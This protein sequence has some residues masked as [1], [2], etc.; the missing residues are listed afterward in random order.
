[1]PVS[2]GPSVRQASFAAFAVAALSTHLASAGIFGE[3][4]GVWDKLWE[5]DEKK[6]EKATSD[7]SVGKLGNVVPTAAAPDTV[8]AALARA[9][10]QTSAVPAVA[11][12]VASPELK[13]IADRA[14]N[15]VSVMKGKDQEASSE[16]TTNDKLREAMKASED[17]IV[18]A[19]QLSK[20]KAAPGEHVREGKNGEIKAKGFVDAA[21]S[22]GS[23]AAKQGWIE[24]YLQPTTTPMPKAP[25]SKCTENCDPKK[26][27]WNP[28]SAGAQGLLD[29]L[30]PLEPGTC[31]DD[32]N[33]HGECS[34][35][36]CSCAGGW[37]GDSCDLQTCEM[38]CQGRGIC[39]G[40]ICACN[41]S[42]YG[43][44]CE[45]IRCPRDC[46]GKG[47]CDLGVCKCDYGYQG[48]DC[49]ELTPTPPP[50][51]TSPMIVNKI[52]FPPTPKHLRAAMKAAKSITPPKCPGDCSG[53]G[54]CELDGTCSCVASFSGLA[55][56]NNCPNGCNGRGECTGGGC[57]C[58]FGFH[59]PDCSLKHCCSGHG[60]CPL[61][62]QCDCWKGFIGAQC[63]EE[64]QCPGGPGC[65][66]H[67]ICYLGECKCA[68]G[69]M[70]AS[71][72]QFNPPSLPPGAGADAM[73]AHMMQSVMMGAATGAAP[74]APMALAQKKHRVEHVVE[75]PE[76]D[77]NHPHGRY[78][79]SIGACVCSESWKGVN[80]R[81]SGCPGSLTNGAQCSGH[82]ICQ[83]GECF[84]V[85]GFGL[86][87]GKSGA[88]M[89][90]DSVCMADCGQ[91]G[92]CQGGQCVCKGG[93]GG[94][95]CREPKCE[96]DCSG[97]GSCLFQAPGQ[98]G[99]CICAAGFTGG[100]CSEPIA[101]ADVTAS[102]F[103]DCSG[104][105]ACV[106]GSCQC[107]AGFT[108]VDCSESEAAI[109]V[110]LEQATLRKEPSFHTKVSLLQKDSSEVATPRH[111]HRRHVEVSE[112]RIA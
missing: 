49:T 15:L 73:R 43:K 97:H 44:S 17:A 35:G 74:M 60:D 95:T 47:Y 37:T 77:C 46:A 98:G 20:Q 55:C 25:K 40:G 26:Q 48:A 82:G 41:A 72:H 2:R 5:S 42:Y 105:G 103:N 29:G 45:F 91:N 63:E 65:S 76:P 78:D 57:L 22:S 56:E 100:D 50:Q 68:P 33:G 92:R 51:A 13:D 53:H 102:C 31:L 87:A 24:S 70:G 96:S 112:V 83:S 18:A 32:C 39:L 64:V 27:T 16:P 84:C 7:L 3:V 10:L 38:N 110:V 23:G 106:D 107:Q 69:W 21:S 86:V 90:A 14:K 94:A 67:G 58:M 75:T 109:P 54:M 111:G 61:P 62:D 19:A 104:R 8:E 108:G 71:C 101:F 6:T 9:R 4:E 11:Q 93:F 28:Q 59:G 12:E 1:M 52:E 79:A 81:D 30:P 99:S 88:N 66:G 89:C 36:Q 34:M 85:S 80:C